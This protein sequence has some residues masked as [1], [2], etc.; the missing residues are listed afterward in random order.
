MVLQRLRPPARTGTKAHDILFTSPG[1]GGSEQV[2]SCCA[3][4]NLRHVLLVSDGLKVGGLFPRECHAFQ[5]RVCHTLTVSR[6]APSALH[7]LRLTTTATISVFAVL[8]AAAAV[9]Q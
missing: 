5:P 9:T 3:A 4:V 7:E 8:T 2:S 6:P 1:G